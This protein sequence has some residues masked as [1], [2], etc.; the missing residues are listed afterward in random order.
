LM[1]AGD[2]QDIDSSTNGT[3]LIITIDRASPKVF[4]RL[5]HP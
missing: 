1:S 3:S 5:R 4:Y 2:W